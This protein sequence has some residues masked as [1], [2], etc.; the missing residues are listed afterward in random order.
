MH[1]ASKTVSTASALPKARDAIRCADEFL[2]GPGVPPE[3]RPY[4]RSGRARMYLRAGFCFYQ[5][6][7]L[8]NAR[9]YYV[10]AHRLDDRRWPSPRLVSLIARTFLPRPLARLAPRVSPTAP[11]RVKM[12]LLAERMLP[13]RMV[14]LLLRTKR[15]FIPSSRGAGSR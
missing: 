6:L 13:A 7:D 9:R 5:G 8:R 3:L 15:R 14:S 1:T 11:A 4:A 2:T 10:Q 12:L